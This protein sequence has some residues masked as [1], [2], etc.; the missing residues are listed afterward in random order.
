M[1]NIVAIALD[2]TV[3]LWNASTSNTECI[4]ACQSGS[5]VCSVSWLK[6]GGDYLAIGTSDNEIQ[7]WDTQS[8]KRIQTM[9]GHQN[10][11]DC[12]A[13]NHYILSSG[14][15]DTQII[16]HDVRDANKIVSVYHG[17]EQ[18]VCNIAWSLDGKYLAS[19]GNDNRLC[20]FTNDFNQNQNPLFTLTDHMAAV[21]ALA[22]CPY[23]R[24]LLASGGGTADRSI[25]LWNVSTGTLL[26][27]VDTGS[28]VCSLC[29]NPH[30]K[31]LLS[32]HGYAKNQLS[33]WKYPNMSLIKE[34]FSHESR[35]LHL[36]VSP[37]G[38]MVCSAGAD[39][40]LAFWRIFGTSQTEKKTV[41][42]S[43][44]FSSFGC[45]R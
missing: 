2:N 4:N 22:W 39:C 6:D 13:W 18:E 33:L 16:N 30:E 35:A 11:V 37:D 23:Q 5:Y 28:Q 29:W 44:P 31:E 27:N 19:G 36:A 24:N 34:F 15:R 41:S 38:T 3:Y 10:R 17:H 9:G 14:S 7:L 20:I 43:M 26:N 42:Q 45:I 25:K 21:K 12:L 40:I 1:N 8:M 32:S